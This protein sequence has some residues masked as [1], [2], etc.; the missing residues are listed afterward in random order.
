[1]YTTPRCLPT[2]SGYFHL[3]CSP[4]CK[5]LISL[6]RNWKQRQKPVLITAIHGHHLSLIRLLNAAS[7]DD[8]LH[9]GSPQLT[10]Q[11][12]RFNLL[13][14]PQECIFNLDSMHPPWCLGLSVQHRGSNRN[15][16]TN[17]ARTLKHHK[18]VSKLILTY[19]THF[20]VLY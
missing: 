17:F 10:V 12:T 16:Q 18:L 2:L 11:G 4:S 1:M 6:N 5:L 19:L 8:L 20:L 15:V 9:R 14:T 13:H 3:L 7:T